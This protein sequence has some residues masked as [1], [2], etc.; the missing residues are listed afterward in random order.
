MDRGVV[1]TTAAGIVNSTV[2]SVSQ[3][4]FLVS[5]TEAINPQ[6]YQEAR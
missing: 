3:R 2:A 6:Q 4:L 5:G 1:G